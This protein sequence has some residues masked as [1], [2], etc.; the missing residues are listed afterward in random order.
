MRIATK[1]SEHVAAIGMGIAFSRYDRDLNVELYFTFL[2]GKVVECLQKA[3]S[4]LPLSRDK[5][6]HNREELASLAML[7]SISIVID[8]IASNIM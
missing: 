5:L 3:T 6:L 8:S 2:L 1:G 4:R 7:N